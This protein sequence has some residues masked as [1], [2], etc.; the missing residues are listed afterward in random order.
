MKALIIALSLFAS[1]AH[2]WGNGPAIYAPDGTYLGRLNNNQF[3][4]DSVSNQFGRYGSQFSPYSINNQM[5][6]YGSMFSSQSPNQIRYVVP[7]YPAE[8]QSPP[9]PSADPYQW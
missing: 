8:P 1:A 9:E 5:G 3:D 2:A 7:S 4:P 6:R